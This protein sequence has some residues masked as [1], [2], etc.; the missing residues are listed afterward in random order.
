MVYYRSI[1]ARFQKPATH[2][3]SPE[4]I[5]QRVSDQ[6]CV[7]RQQTQQLHLNITDGGGDWLQ[8]GGGNSREPIGRP[9]DQ[10]PSVKISVER[11]SMYN[12]FSVYGG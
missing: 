7:P 11:E 12:S 8:H 5:V 10:I 2:F 4:V 1:N 3:Q 6:D 9:T